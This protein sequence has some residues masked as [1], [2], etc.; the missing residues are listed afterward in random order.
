MSNT[1][2]LD[3]QVGG[4]AQPQLSSTATFVVDTKVDLTVTKNADATVAPGA[5]NR[6]LAFTVTNTGNAT[7]GYSLT[8]VQAAGATVTM[9][10]VRIFRDVN[11]NG[12]YDS[13]TDTLYTAGTNA[14]DLAADAPGRFLIVADTPAGATSGQT[15]SW[16]LVARTLNAGSTTV[17]AEST[18]ADNKDT[19]QVVFADGDGDAAAA[20]DA[21]RDGR[22]TASGAFTVS[23]ATI[24][25]AKTSTVVSDPENNT[26]NPKRIPGAVVRYSITASNAAGGASAATV[27]LTDAIPANTTY[28]T[29]S[30][31]LNSVAKTD[32]SDADEA[33]YNVSVAGAVRGNVGT[34]AAGG[35]ATVTFDVTIQ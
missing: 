8:A 16:Y 35:S 2:T 1:V 12:A 11:A 19:V 7:Q 30:I 17:T 4:T 18:G 31:T 25:L 21:A 32:A 13:G 26:T 27:V 6:V 20:N 24:T 3:Y 23:A 34:I 28:V 14:G 10:N 5:T 9:T 29:G 22:H 15:A 33:N